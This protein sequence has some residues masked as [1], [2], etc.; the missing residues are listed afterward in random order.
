[1][2]SWVGVGAVLVLLVAADSRG[3]EV[4]IRE[5]GTG[6]T[7]IVAGVGAS[8]D[9][10]LFIDTQGLTFEGYS[11]GVDFTGGSVN[12]I[13]VS[14]STLAGLVPD[15]FGTPVID[16]G[17]DT[18]RNS[19]QATLVVGP[20]LPAGIYTVDVISIIISSFSGDTIF[21]TPGLFGEALGLGEG[22][23][24]GTVPGCSVT[25]A[26]ASITDISV[27]P[28]PGAALLLALVVPGLVILRRSGLRGRSL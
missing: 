27:V 9:L 12:M 26:S 15:L 6:D 1:M 5:V 23:C 16:D 8:I 2:R 21:V 24:P 11:L 4:G 18:I 25:F 13:G 10:E 28:E 7:A 22:S 19:N 3:A 14:H 20:G 17:A